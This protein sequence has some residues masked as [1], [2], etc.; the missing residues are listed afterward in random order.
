[1]QDEQPNV[2]A[3]DGLTPLHRAAAAGD[4][5]A[6]RR[7]IGAGADVNART[8]RLIVDN[9]PAEEE[10][11]PGD[12]PLILAAQR[13][14]ADIVTLLLERGANASGYNAVRWGPLHAAVVGGHAAALEMLIAA[15]ADVELSC[16][17]R[18]ADEQLGWFF[19]GTPLHLASSWN[20]A[21]MAEI[22]IQ[23]GA[24]LSSA[25]VDR[26]TPLIYAAA[27]G[28]TA[29]VEVLCQHGADPNLREHRHEYGYFIDWTP[30]HYAARNGHKETVAALR[31]LGAE[32]RAR[33]SHSGETAEEMARAAE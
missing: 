14:H 27:R 6:C 18:G 16:V 12:T 29:V 3:Q 20:R 9:E 2:R 17:A 1:M 23:S 10:W 25:W 22:L 15:G 4:L 13:G 21:Q 26:R 28:S 19:V 24:N 8:G 32:P 30:L 31:R 5:A 33:D 7:W 11:E